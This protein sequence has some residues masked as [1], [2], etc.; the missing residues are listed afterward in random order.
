MPFCPTLEWD[1]LLRGRPIVVAENP[2]NS[3]SAAN[4]ASRSVRSWRSTQ[5]VRE[6]LVNPLAMVVRGE[7]VQVLWQVPFASGTMRFRHPPL[8]RDRIAESF[9]EESRLASHRLTQALNDER[10]IRIRRATDRLYTPRLH[11]EHEGRVVRHQ[12]ANGPHF[13]R[14]EVCRH[15]TGQCACT[16]VR[17]VIGRGG[18]GGM[19][20]ARRVRRDRGAANAMAQVFEA[21]WIRV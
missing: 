1:R 21:P 5:L 3:L 12:A 2:G 18:A 7:F 10:F 17:Q 16:N 13:G 15:R 6:A 14:E 19:P 9:V 4:D 11:V 8:D 20:F